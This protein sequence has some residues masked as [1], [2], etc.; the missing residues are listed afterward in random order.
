MPASR[1]GSSC[2]ALAAASRWLG[3]LN[4]IAVLGEL[5]FALGVLGSDVAPPDLTMPLACFLVGVVASGLSMACW[6]WGAGG[7]EERP[8]GVSGLARW[9][10]LLAYLLA[11]AAFVVGCWLSAGLAFEAEAGDVDA[12]YTMRIPGA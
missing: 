8:V 9:V 3:W 10:G 2:A 4:A 5:G 7:A 1:H 11:L 6:A 12:G